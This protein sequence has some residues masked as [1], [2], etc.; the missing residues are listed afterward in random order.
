MDDDT[1][2]RSVKTAER[3]FRIIELL[4]DIEEASLTTIADHLDMP[5]STLHTYLSTLLDQQYLTKEGNTY[6]LSLKFLDYGVKVQQNEPIY[7]TCEPF[8]EQVAHQT[9]EIA[10]VVVEEYGRAVCLRKAE[11][12]LAI[13]PYK[14]VGARLSM[15]DIAAGKAL[16]AELS[17]DRVHEIIDQY[18]LPRRTENTITDPD[19]LFDELDEI[20][21]TGVAFNDGES[22]DGFRAVA[23]PIC[24]NGEL[25][26]ALVV[27]GPKN[28]FQDDRFR[29]ELP[30]VVTGTTNAI[31]LEL[32]SST[33]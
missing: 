16:L 26:G 7:G 24:P 25:H 3:A 13:Q 10:W 5:R 4:D 8:L 20:R 30:E 31:E 11:G 1:P 33:T 23:S 17:D 27:S 14:R 15:H 28:R 6:R 21:E 12:E 18:G 19:A 9:E 22:M 2:G 29:D 32:F